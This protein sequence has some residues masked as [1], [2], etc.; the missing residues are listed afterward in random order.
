LYFF[1]LPISK[2][3]EVQQI[4]KGI[5]MAF[6]LTLLLP[7]LGIAGFRSVDKMNRGKTSAGIA[8]E[9]IKKIESK[10]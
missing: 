7:M 3:Q 9:S 10:N 5:D 6:L 8:I 2:I 1:D 4:V